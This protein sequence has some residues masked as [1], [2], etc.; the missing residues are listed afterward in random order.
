M[1]MTL[2][3]TLREV[4]IDIGHNQRSPSFKC[5]RISRKVCWQGLHQHIVDDSE[6]YVG[7]QVKHACEKDSEACKREVEAPVRCR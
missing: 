7:S 1:T 5:Q 2:T 3:M 6:Q 4:D